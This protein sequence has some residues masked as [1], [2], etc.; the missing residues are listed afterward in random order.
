M[1]DPLPP[2]DRPMCS[3]YP[4]IQQVVY[5]GEALGI[6]SIVISPQRQANCLLTIILTD[7][8]EATAAHLA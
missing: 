3:F 1:K 4:S 6:A 5:M 8:L 7:I 2:R